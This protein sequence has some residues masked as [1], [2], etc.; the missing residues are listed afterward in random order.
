MPFLS[1][2]YFHM[3]PVNMSD[4]MIADAVTSAAV[5]VFSAA[6][7]IGSH[8]KEP[9]DSSICCFC[10]NV[11]IMFNI[12]YFFHIFTLSQ[13]ADFFNKI[14]AAAKCLPVFCRKFQRYFWLHL[15][16]FCCS[17]FPKEDICLKDSGCSGILAQGFFL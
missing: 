7:A 15:C 12:M 17:L 3:A 13:I 11:V 14:T 1:E 16:H 5:Y 4:A 8:G 2:I 6:K 9:M 10:Q